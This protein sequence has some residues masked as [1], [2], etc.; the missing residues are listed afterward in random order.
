MA[1]SLSD[2][3][4]TRMQT[5]LI[6]L[7]TLNYELEANCQRH[8]AEIDQLQEKYGNQEKELQ[9]A[10]KIINKSKNRKEYAVLLEENENLQRQ[11]QAQEENFKLQNQTLLEEISKLNDDNEKLQK[12]VTAKDGGQ[13][14]GTDAETRRLRAENAALQKSLTNSQQRH[15]EELLQL[16]EKI[17]SLSDEHDDSCQSDLQNDTIPSSAESSENGK[18]HETDS[19]QTENKSGHS[20]TTGDVSNEQE[21]NDRHK[22]AEGYEENSKSEGDVETDSKESGVGTS[23]VSHEFESG[24]QDFIEEIDNLKRKLIDDLA[25]LISSNEDLLNRTAVV[26]SPARE[27]RQEVEIRSVNS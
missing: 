16:Q 9:K 6:E 22:V 10:N 1:Q 2:E 7:R 12:Q 14:S 21:T 13:D 27:R 3:E 24:N 15:E 20:E 18:K 25:L 17:Q 11:F 26:R 19:E 23:N 8:Q 4:F 5:Q